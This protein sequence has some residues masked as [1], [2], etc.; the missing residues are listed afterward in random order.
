MRPLSPIVNHG[1]RAKC[2][3]SRVSPDWS[4]P[5]KH[6]ERVRIMVFSVGFKPRLIYERPFAVTSCGEYGRP[7]HWGG[8]LHDGYVK[9]VGKVVELAVDLPSSDHHDFAGI[10]CLCYAESLADVVRDMDAGK[11]VA[12]LF[13]QNDIVPAIQRLA[14]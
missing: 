1:R 12:L 9:T 13:R 6:A 5:V 3:T 10:V 7:F 2:C 14:D 11:C 4:G 8:H